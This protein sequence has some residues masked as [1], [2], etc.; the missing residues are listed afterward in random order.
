MS[1]DDPRHGTRNGYTN[2]T[3]R[4]DRC[5]AAW[6]DYVYGIRRRR[7]AFEDVPEHGT[8]NGYVNYRCRCDDCRAA[9]NEYKRRRRARRSNPGGSVS[10]DVAIRSP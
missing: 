8:L 10:R 9:S 1:P 3:C 2:L 4:C 7:A 5:R 6:A